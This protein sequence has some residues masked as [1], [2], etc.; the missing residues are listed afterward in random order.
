MVN[1][2]VMYPV[3]LIEHSSQKSL[4]DVEMSNRLYLPYL[5]LYN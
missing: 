4:D 5:V 2:S 1:A 3:G